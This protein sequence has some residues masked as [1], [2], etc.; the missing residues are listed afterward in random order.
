MKQKKQVQKPKSEVFEQRL[1][2]YWQYIA[3]YS[4]VLLVYGVVKGSL[5]EGTI[6]LVL[7]DPIV[8]LLSLF[9]VISALS[10]LINYYK[11]KTIIVGADF[12]IFKSRFGEKEYKINDIIKINVGNEKLIKVRRGSYRVIKIKL[13][14]RKW[15]LKIRPSTFWDESGLVQAVSNLKKNLNR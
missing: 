6:T 10:M 4:V 14:T 3:L 5:E 15:M 2:F 9:I 1:D 8:A 13:A 12:I 11:N 7:T